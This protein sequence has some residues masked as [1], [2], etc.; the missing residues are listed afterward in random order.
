[1]LRLA[2]AGIALA[3]SAA[4]AL[5]APPPPVEDPGNAPMRFE[6]RR[7]GPAERVRL[8]LSRLD[9]GRRL[10]D[11]R[12]R[13]RVRGLCG[14]EGRSRSGAGA[15]FR[16]R[17]GAGHDRARSRH[18]PARNGDDRGQDHAAAADRGR[19]SSRQADAQRQLRIH[20]RLPAARR[21]PPLRAAAGARAGAP[22]LA[23]QE[24]QE[25]ARLRAIRPRSSTWSSATSGAWRNTR[26]RWAAASI[27]SRPPCGFR[28]GS[29]ST[30]S[31]RKRSSGCGSTPSRRCSIMSR[32]PRPRSP[33]AAAT[34]ATV[35][36]PAPRRD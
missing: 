3:C 31:P 11:Q 34:L 8:E 24:A 12:Y 35:G 27:C 25:R 1:M 10:F 5:A 2:W 7:E 13:A 22:D 4:F 23:R 30:R 26:S 36:H 18:P 14:K 16:R 9:F 28:R 21:H 33:P 17:L 29:R 20:V 19:R 15:R 32:R 6:W